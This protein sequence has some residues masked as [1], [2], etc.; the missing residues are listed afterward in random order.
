VSL[1]RERLYIGLS[2]KYILGC[3]TALPQYTSTRVNVLE[4]RDMARTNIK[5][6]DGRVS[7]GRSDSMRNTSGTAA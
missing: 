7:P 4:Q 1:S 2:E 5:G 3:A 6:L